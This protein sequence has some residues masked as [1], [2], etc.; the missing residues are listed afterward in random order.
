[1]K[2]KTIPW[3]EVADGVSKGVIGGVAVGAAG[4]SLFNAAITSAA[5]TVCNQIGGTPGH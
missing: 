3:S 5:G 2:N 4:P 1:M